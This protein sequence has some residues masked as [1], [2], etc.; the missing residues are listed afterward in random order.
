MSITNIKTLKNAI[1]LILKVIR[2]STDSIDEI[3]ESGFYQ[4]NMEAN[5]SCLLIRV[6]LPSDSNIFPEI[7]AGKHRFSIRFLKT[8]NPAHRPE[9]EKQDVHFRLACCTL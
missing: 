8:Q 9:Q 7:S 1:T 3:A 4:K 5:Q 6:I 2:E